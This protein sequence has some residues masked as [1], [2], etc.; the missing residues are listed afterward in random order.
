MSVIIKNNL[1][2]I[3]IHL[4]M[5]LFFLFPILL[6]DAIGSWAL[7]LLAPIVFYLY[8]WAGKKYLNNTHNTFTNIFSVMLLAIVLA[9]TT[10]A[11]EGL[12]ALPFYS[13][14]LMISF[15]F[16]MPYDAAEGLYV[17]LLLVPFLSLTMLV[18][19]L[20]KQR[21]DKLYKNEPQNDENLE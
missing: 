5:C 3:A 21:R 12:T 17:C 16:Q 8:F 2:A 20:V 7:F 6:L 11:L 18:G 13:L 4:G 19:L 14:F 1:I 9:V 15:I 10:Y